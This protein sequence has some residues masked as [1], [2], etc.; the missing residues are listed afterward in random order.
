MLVGPRSQLESTK[1]AFHEVPNRSSS[2]SSHGKSTA[3]GRAGGQA[4]FR[5][6]VYHGGVQGAMPPCLDES[7]TTT[8][9]RPT[10]AESGRHSGLLPPDLE[11]RIHLVRFKQSPAAVQQER[12]I[13]SFEQPSARR[14]LSYSASIVC[15]DLG[16]GHDA[17]VQR[18]GQHDNTEPL[19]LPHEDPYH[20]VSR[21]RKTCER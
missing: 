2:G 12:S 13:P 18:A 17:Q 11:V 16:S 4:H 5:V 7:T 15:L 9:D 20:D 1:L 19:H 14:T 10:T 8:V 3:F 6:A 21:H